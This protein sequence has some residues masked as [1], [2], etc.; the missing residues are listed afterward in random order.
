MPTKEE[1]IQAREAAGLTQFQALRTLR[2][3]AR[4]AKTWNQWERNG[5]M[6]QDRFDHF[7]MLTKTARKKNAAKQGEE[8]D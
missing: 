6:P 1:I 7:L 5:K 2:P 4:T 8:N 3:E